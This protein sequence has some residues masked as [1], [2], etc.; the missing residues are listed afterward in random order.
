MNGRHHDDRRDDA[1][2][3][4]CYEGVLYGASAQRRARC[5]RK[6]ALL[7][8]INT[9][10]DSLPIVSSPMAAPSRAREQEFGT[11]SLSARVSVLNEDNNEAVSAARG[12]TKRKY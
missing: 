1:P 10:L 11:K 5:W 12:A 7:A 2:I 3:T 4:A 9:P 8:I 6:K